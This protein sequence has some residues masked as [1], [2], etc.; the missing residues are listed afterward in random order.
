MTRRYNGDTRTPNKLSTALCSAPKRSIIRT[1]LKFP[2]FKGEYG[3]SGRLLVA[4]EV[5]KALGVLS[6][7]ALEGQRKLSQPFDFTADLPQQ[8]LP[9]SHLSAVTLC[10]CATLARSTGHH[11]FC[12]VR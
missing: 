10:A 11:S 8:R 4:R 12:G 7:G 2:Y 3:R 9:R 5:F 6:I 1:L